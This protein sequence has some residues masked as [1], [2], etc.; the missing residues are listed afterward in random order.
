[1]TAVASMPPDERALRAHLDGAEF[2]DGVA[3]GRWRVAGGVEWPNVVIAVSA[4]PRPNG[5]PEFFLRFDLAGYPASP[6]AITPWD[7][8]T[9][10]VLAPDRRP[11]GEHAA[12]VFRP[13]W[14]SGKDL[15]LPFDRAALADHPQW[16]QQ[17]PR[18]AWNADRTLAWALRNIHDLLNEPAYEGA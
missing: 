3:R 18:R 8:E 13:D 14:K 6:P 9:N 10:G 2:A 11:K 17:Y 7:P 5:P 16:A 4:A 15:Y 1:M 12:M